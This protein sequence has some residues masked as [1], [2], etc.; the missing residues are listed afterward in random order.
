VSSRGRTPYRCSASVAPFREALRAPLAYEVSKESVAIEG[1]L[2]HRGQRTY[3]RLLE[4]L[5]T[6]ET[7]VQRCVVGQRWKLRDHRRCGLSSTDDFD[8]LMLEVAVVVVVSFG[9]H[10]V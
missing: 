5:Q 1:R 10:R 3:D 4:V 8:A 6:S 9:S 2:S 7:V